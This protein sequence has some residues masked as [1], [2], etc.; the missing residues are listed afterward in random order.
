MIFLGEVSE[1]QK[2]ELEQYQATVKRQEAELVEV[3][4]QLAK[5][6]EIVDQQTDDMKQLNAEARFVS[7]VTDS[8]HWE[9]ASRGEGLIHHWGMGQIPGDE[10]EI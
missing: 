3:R 10:F 4:Q 7:A 9:N 2:Q 8:L 6:S 1:S 5:L